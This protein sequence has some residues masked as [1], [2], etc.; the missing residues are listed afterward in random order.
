MV[1]LNELI[2]T[3]DYISIHA[4]LTKETRNMFTIE[5]FKKMKSG[6]YLINT[7]RGG[8]VNE[9]DL[10]VACKKNM[11]AGAALDVLSEEPI[12]PNH[13]LLELPNVLITPHMAWYTEEAIHA[14]K[15]SVAEEA[16]RVLNGEKPINVVNDKAL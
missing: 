6:S 15:E 5:E 8:I 16:V 13:F 7:A 1:E 10:Y 14:L 9:K 4:P 11:I 2:S 3:S 12:Q